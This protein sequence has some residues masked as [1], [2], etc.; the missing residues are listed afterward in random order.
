MIQHRK[1]HLCGMFHDAVTTREYLLKAEISTASLA[2]TS[3]S[4]QQVYL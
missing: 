4:N 3:L 2:L 1:L